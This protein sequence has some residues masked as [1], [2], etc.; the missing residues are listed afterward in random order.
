MTFSTVD[1]ISIQ[2]AAKIINEK[3]YARGQLSRFSEDDKTGLNSSNSSN[4]NPNLSS[5]R[6]EIKELLFMTLDQDK[7]MESQIIDDNQDQN[8]DIENIENSENEN[9]HVANT[10]SKPSTSS[11]N[12]KITETMYDNDK[13]IINVIYSLL[14]S[15]D[16]LRSSR[17]NTLEENKTLSKKLSEQQREINRLNELVN[18]KD[19]QIIEIS[20]VNLKLKEN[21]KNSLIKTLN[22]NK[23]YN[24]LQN[25]LDDYKNYSI[26]EIKRFKYENEILKNKI[27]NV[28]DRKIR[29]SSRSNN[30][31]LASSSPLTNSDISKKE[32]DTNKKRKLNA[33]N[34]WLEMKEN[35]EESF[36]SLSK[37]QL[38]N[39]SLNEDITAMYCFIINLFN[40]FQNFRKVIH[41]ENSNLL[42]LVFE[43]D[44]NEI[45]NGDIT[46]DI[47]DI[48]SK[49][50]YNN[51][52][53]KAITDT[54]INNKPLP[55]S[56]I[57]LKENEMLSYDQSLFDLHVLDSK[58]INLLKHLYQEIYGE[59]E[60]NGKIVN[61]GNENDHDNETKMKKSIKK[62]LED[63]MISQIQE[64][65]LL[66]KQKKELEVNYDKVLKTMEDWKTFKHKKGRSITGTEQQ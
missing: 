65:Q 64:I 5:K 54:K 39:K 19:R 66:K 30:S 36:L 49:I 41:D 60:E 28:L 38:E 1:L 62:V 20:S 3:L 9:T 4:P 16:S 46:T 18:S 32:N 42:E 34:T 40:S 61:G 13:S 43:D 63:K 31:S 35:S 15:I 51:K 2:N 24:Y 14:D 8:A 53:K 57:P 48:E 59:I 37:L 23:K 7:I 21:N 17:N 10:G 56:L 22:L 11:M 45:Y 58:F 55:N 50:A 52:L 29:I 27:N 44:N 33:N 47:N 26:K 6:L 25:Q 12:Y